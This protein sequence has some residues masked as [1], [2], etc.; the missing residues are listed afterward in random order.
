M[1][2][3]QANYSNGLPNRATIL[4][5]LHANYDVLKGYDRRLK[6]RYAEFQTWRDQLD[7]GKS[8]REQTGFPGMPTVSL[9]D[10]A[11]V[12]ANSSDM[13]NFMDTDIVMYAHGLHLSNQRV[14][15]SADELLSFIFSPTGWDQ[16]L[17]V[18]SYNITDDIF[19]EVISQVD[20]TLESYEE[21]VSQ[22]PQ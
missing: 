18:V 13:T 5:E 1:A 10:S 7:P 22:Y 2:R 21:F 6:E 12:R 9:N 4:G 15:D 17:T 8:Y 11:W 14:M 3:R 20:Q 19:T 16:D